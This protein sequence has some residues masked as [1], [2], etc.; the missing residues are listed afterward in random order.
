[1]GNLLMDDVFKKSE[2]TE[3]EFLLEV[4]I[5]LYSKEK[6]TLGQGSKFAEL[7]QF[8]FQK[9]LG[10]RKIPTHYGIE[11]LHDDLTNLGIPYS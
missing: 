8:I 9:E 6:L 11:D 2:M 3:K 10:K 5:W 1:M 7:P 4:A